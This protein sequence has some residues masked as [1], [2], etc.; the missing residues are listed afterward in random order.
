[1]SRSLPSRIKTVEMTIP[2]NSPNPERPDLFVSRFAQ[3]FGNFFPAEELHIFGKTG[4]PRPGP[5]LHQFLEFAQRH[6]G[7]LR[8]LRPFLPILFPNRLRIDAENDLA[9]SRRE[10]V[11]FA[12][13]DI[14]APGRL[15][16]D[17]LAI[18]INDR[19][20]LIRLDHM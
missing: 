12:V 2:V 8:Q 6:S 3:T 16:H 5:L 13:D 17:L 14:A 9:S 19:R 1:M 18:L 20:E 11:S 15:D 7:E 10:H 4:F